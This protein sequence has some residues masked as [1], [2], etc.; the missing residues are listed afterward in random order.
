ML[1]QE[2]KM[3]NI[4]KPISGLMMGTDYFSPDIID[5]V[6]ENMENFIKIGGNTL[7]TAHIYLGGKSEEAIGIWMEENKR[8]DDI[9]SEEHTSELQSRGH[10][11]CRLLL[12]KKKR[13]KI[14]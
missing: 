7:D 4:K 1:M 10:L 11:V 14:K 9:R 5:T 12:E 8:R 6:A 2:V 3:N 13:N